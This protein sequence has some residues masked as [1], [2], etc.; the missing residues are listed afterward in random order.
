MSVAL[1][2]G[3]FRRLGAEI[4][5]RLA[6]DGHD[7]AL[8]GRAGSV[9]ETGLPERLQ[10]MDVRS[11]VFHADLTQETEIAALVADVEATF[12]AP[13]AILVNN[14]ARFD[15]DRLESVGMDSLV[16]HFEANTASAILLARHF[17]AS[18]TSGA[19]GVV[20]NVLD[21]RIANPHPDQLSYTISKQAIAVATRTLAVALAPR[22][23]VC[24]V[25]PGLT[26]PTD[27]YEESQLDRLAAMMPLE[28]L[29]RPRE[30]ADAVAF[31]VAAEAVTGQILFVD[32]GAW[33]RTYPRDFVYLGKEN[34]GSI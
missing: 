10:A 27:A 19:R 23:R 25:A 33:L 21:Q 30:V 18:L 32:A 6:A 2:T 26:I 12:G 31:L 3:S 16:A 22:I 15:D 14:A 17:A 9:P 4:A 7:I 11:G 1:V 28:R 34:G 13:P 29:A 8:Q 5:L 24:G 20:V